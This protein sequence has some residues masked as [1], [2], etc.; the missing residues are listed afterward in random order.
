MTMNL[1][2]LEDFQALAE[3]GNFSRAAE[4]RHMTQPAFGRRIKALEEW[5]GTPLFDRSGHPVT[6]TEPGEWLRGTAEQLLRRVERLPDEAR[7]VADGSAS[8]LRFAATHALSLNFLPAW[9]RGLERRIAIG[10]IQLVS[11]VAAHCEA[12]L[13]HGRVQ[14]LLCHGHERAPSGLDPAS[15]VSC[16]IGGDELLP[17]CAPDAQRRPR[18]DLDAAPRRGARAAL[19]MLAYSAESG[20][21]RA[22]RSLH[23]AALEAPGREVV[24]TAHLATVLRS[25]ALEGRGLAFLPASLVREDLAGGRLVAAGGA[26]WTIAL[27]VR[28]YR[29]RAALS[30]VAEKFWAAA[31]QATG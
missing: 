26:R 22:L 2:W 11:D 3:S 25:L 13:Q 4:Q 27:S 12:Q 14:F 20:L 1:S 24:F 15:F 7:A 6:L 29:P 16:E 19:P 31:S 30:A 5:L 10:P 21:G 23:G 8:T 18:F 28:L 17:V 9:L